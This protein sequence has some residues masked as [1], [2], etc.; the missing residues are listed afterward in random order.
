MNLP[1]KKY[2]ILLLF[3]AIYCCIACDGQST[4]NQSSNIPSKA[5]VEASTSLPQTITRT[6]IQDR[7]GIIWFTSWKGIFQFENNVFTNIT[8]EVSSHRFFSIME[9]RNENLW[10]ASV[11]G[12]VYYYD[13]NSFK[14]FTTKDGLAN[15]RV[16]NIYEDNKD[17]IWFS[18]ETGISIF[19]G[20]GFK[21]IY[22]K[23]GET[24]NDNDINAV[25]ES[26]AGTF[27]VA[28][29]G[30]AY[31]YEDEKFIKIIRENGL[32]FTNVR[33]IVKDRENNIWLGGND[34]LWRFDGK[35][36]TQLS[37]N[38]TGYIYEDSDGNILTSSQNTTQS[39]KDWTISQSNNSKDWVLTRYDASFLHQP[40]PKPTILLSQKTMLFGILKDKEKNTWVGMLSG[41]LLDSGAGFRQVY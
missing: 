40:K 17:N 5:E 38:F 29:R 26:T 9:D 27:W 35:E 23:K 31:L 16:T 7:R 3:A 25:L 24:S 13:R 10:F 18:T 11:G 4:E 1:T 33:S 39:Q 20:K 22:P 12:G 32:D 2:Q 15:N 36:Y 34:G 14:N 28:T 19:D 21:N 30:K 8:K 41:A 6:I 37:K